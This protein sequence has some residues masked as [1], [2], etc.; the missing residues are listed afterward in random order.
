M[1]KN[2]LLMSILLLIFETFVEN[3][4]V[5]RRSIDNQKTEVLT[6]VDFIAYYSFENQRY[7]MRMAK[8]FL[9]VFE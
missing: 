5:I 2:R 3:V 7:V 1:V 8:R 9:A 4:C 6:E